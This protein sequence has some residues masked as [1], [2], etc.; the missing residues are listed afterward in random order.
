MTLH[1]L[2]L[3]LNNLKFIKDCYFDLLEQDN[4]QFKLTIIDQASTEEGTIE[5]LEHINNPNV[6]V[7][8]NQYNKPVNEMWNWFAN[9]SK[10]DLICF[11]NNDVRLTKNFVSDTI[12]LFEKEPKVGIAA[13]ATNNPSFKKPLSKLLYQVVEPY[14]YMQGWDFTLRRKL[15]LD[16]PSEIKI[17]CGDDFIYHS[18]YIRGYDMAYIIS[19]PIIHYEGQSKKYMRT[20]GLEDIAAFKSLGFK[21]YLTSASPF[22]RIKPTFEHFEG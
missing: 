22:S 16:I 20:S 14:K 12:E 4:K 11:L 13:H 2:I 10:A 21:H 3:N 6:E 7:I 15:F 1:I 9:T 18:M 5:F 19:S 8:F 17:Y